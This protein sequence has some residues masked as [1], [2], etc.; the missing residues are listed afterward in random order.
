MVDSITALN[1]KESLGKEQVKPKL[2][3]I[4]I[5]GLWYK[6]YMDDKINGGGVFNSKIEDFEVKWYHHTET[7]SEIQLRHNTNFIK[8]V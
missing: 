4:D 5:Y 3:S 8:N 7:G 1:T 2:F 6:K